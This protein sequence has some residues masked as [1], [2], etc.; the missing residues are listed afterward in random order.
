[1][2]IITILSMVLFFTSC[3]VYDRTGVLE[4][5]EGKNSF[6]TMSENDT[7]FR[8]EDELK[9]TT[10]K[11]N[12][13]LKSVDRD[14]D[15]LHPVE[16]QN[17]NLENSFAGQN[18]Q[19][20][21]FSAPKLGLKK[22]KNLKKANQKPLSW[23]NPPTEII[24]RYSDGRSELMAILMAAFGLVFGIAVP[25]LSDNLVRIFRTEAILM[26]VWIIQTSFFDWS[27]S[28]LG[29]LSDTMLILGCIGLYVFWLALLVGI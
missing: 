10:L 21:V 8:P 17:S 5:G 6:Y 13:E 20:P 18:V 4:R 23:N 19:S 11:V 22:I 9:K 3:S 7:K 16:S 26:A 28:D 14:L 12:A 29:W 27:V 24:G 25:F 1:M 15:Q 2:R